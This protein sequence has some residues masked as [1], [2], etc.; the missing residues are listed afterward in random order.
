MKL[1]KVLC[2]L[3]LVLMLGQQTVFAA[4]PAPTPAK[5]NEHSSTMKVTFYSDSL[6]KEM[7]LNVY[8]PPN[9]DAQEKYPVLYVLHSYKLNE[10]HWFDTLKMKE[11]ADA[12]IASKKITPMIIVAP[13]IENSFGVNSSKELGYEEGSGNPGDP[14]VLNKGMY[15]D[16]ITKDVITYIDTHFKTIQSRNS[17]YIGGT[18]MGGFAAL[19]I[20]LSNPLLFSKVGGHAPALFVGDMWAP[21]KNLVYPTDEIRKHNDPLLLAASQKL[22]KQSIYLDCG[23]Q[24]DFIA[25]TKQLDKVLK[26]KKTKSYEFHVIEGGHH[27][28]AY[29]SSQMENYLMFYGATDHH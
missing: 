10:D 21:L 11:Q 16:Y 29:W 25:A 15:E 22:N 12:L 5:A 9:Y 19:H 23:D 3:V 6:H 2:A 17:R 14:G 27:D 7:Q 18:S 8:L 4:A 13:R 1:V 24:D 28:D 20:G 26:M